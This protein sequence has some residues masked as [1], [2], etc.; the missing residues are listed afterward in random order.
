MKYFSRNHKESGTRRKKKKAK[1]NTRRSQYGPTRHKRTKTRRNLKKIYGGGDK[2]KASEEENENNKRQKYDENNLMEISTEIID[3][4]VKKEDPSFFDIKKIDDNQKFDKTL[5]KKAMEKYPNVPYFR[6]IYDLIDYITYI[7]ADTFMRVYAD[8]ARDLYEISENENYSHVILLLPINM[9]KHNIKSNLFFTLYFYNM[10]LNKYPSLKSKLKI[11]PLH[12]RGNTTVG[13]F[14]EMK[15]LFVICD[16]FLY[17][18]WQITD[19]LNNF[20]KTNKNILPEKIRVFLNIVGHSERAKNLLTKLGETMDIIKEEKNIIHTDKNMKWV[21]SS[22]ISD[23]NKMKKYFGINYDTNHKMD[24]ET[25]LSYVTL[26]DTEGN[27]V[28]NSYPSAADYVTPTITYLF[29]KYPDDVSAP[30]KICRLK[31]SKYKYTEYPNSSEVEIDEDIYFVNNSGKKLYSCASMIIPFY[32]SMK[33]LSD[34]QT[35]LEKKIVEE[36]GKWQEWIKHTK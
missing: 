29:F 11:L 1:I 9:H 6:F 8:N 20:N 30:Q 19:H 33:K 15:P 16:D 5:A 24:E 25:F 4:L 23:E 26:T 18:G 14:K 35:N 32:K 3:N 31:Q 21:I 2:R 12:S 34:L 10:L 13:N 7:D 17:S 22:I 27:S 36:W 28:L